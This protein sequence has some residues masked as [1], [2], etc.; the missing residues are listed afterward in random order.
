MASESVLQRLAAEFDDSPETISAVVDMFERGASPQFIARYRRDET[1]DPGEER[2]TALEERWHFLHDLEARKEAILEQAQQRAGV[3][4]ELRE[5]LA[6]T[7]DQ[8]LLDDIYQSFRPRRRTPG[9]QAAERGLGPLAEA[10]HHRQ[11]ADKSLQE[12]AADY[13]SAE[14]EL[15]T[16][17]AVLEGVLHILAERY[18]ADPQLRAQLRNEMSRGVLKA[19]ATS[20]NRKGA[21]RY[22]EF[23]AFEEPVRRIGAQRMLALRRAEREGIVKIELRLPQGREIEVYRERFAADLPA[24]APLHAFLDLVFQ[25]SFDQLVRPGCEA[26]IRRRIKEKADRE[27]LRTFS[28]NLRSQLLAP[29]LGEKRTLVIRASR[30]TVWCAALDESGAVEAQHVLHL[31]DPSAE[32]APSKPAADA[33]PAAAASDEAPADA[34]AEAPAPP[35]ET[36]GT[37]ASSPVAQVPATESGPAEDPPPTPEAPTPETTTAADAPTAEAPSAEAPEETQPAGAEP[38]ET[39]PEGRRRSSENCTLP[40]AVAKLIE[41]A[42]QHRPAAIAIPHGRRQDVS[43]QVARDVLAGLEN[44]VMLIPVDEA[45]STIYATSAAGRK[46]MPQAEVGVRTAIHLGR[47]LQ[48]PLLQLLHLDPRDLGLG[49]SLADVHQGMLATTL[50][51]TV[52]SC[53]AL[54][55]VDVNRANTDTLSRLPG[56]NRDQARA[57]VEHR[58]KAG[59]FRTRTGIGEVEGIDENAVRHVAGFLRLA[60][61]EQPLD[62]TGVHPDDFD[63]AE[64]IAAQVGEPVT[65]LLGRDV[66]IDLDAVTSDGHPRLRTLDVLGALAQAG[67]DPRGQLSP[68]NNPGVQ[69]VADL[70]VDMQLRGRV[71]NVTDFG[72][73]VDLG[74]GQDGLV[75]ISQIPGRRLKNP[76]QAL[77]IGEVIRIYVVRIDKDGKRISLTM[78]RPRH[79]AE[80][81][82]PTLGERMQGGGRRGR[83][84][85]DEG[86]VMTRA[87]RA[88]DGRRDGRRGGPR[89]GGQGPGGGRPGGRGFGRR[90]DGPRRSGPPRVITVESERPV[91]QSRGHKGELRSLS[92]LRNLLGDKKSGESDSSES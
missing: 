87:A 88:P 59:G 78:L 81:R 11:L 44:D 15:P 61:G 24:E 31:W 12:L 71:T 29:P 77:R 46:A 48:D 79:L 73:F 20:P 56:L 9:V 52:G 39:E 69:S 65:G 41:L 51:H 19:E 18:A 64:K 72:A 76:D 36:E 50:D 92:G 60:G 82:A 38:A 85:R 25:H 2:L 7:Y 66:R 16:A 43:L 57:I 40:E 28:R 14:N 83:G 54:V 37:D 70:Q 84:R 22:Q 10:I 80:G 1:R 45:P 3:T 90:D 8:D 21:K 55:G 35:P 6:Q 5:T 32:K 17:E 91:E 47:R 13:I 58:Q 62:V 53:L 42:R 89:R 27:T 26:D 67:R 68:W 74:V 23:F 63:L 75:H 34:P 33:Q 4:D 86:Q 30:R 49:A